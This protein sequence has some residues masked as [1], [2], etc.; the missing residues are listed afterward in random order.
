MSWQ[1]YIDQ[2]L[3]G[4]GN[5]DK[6]AIYDST[7]KS[8]WATSSNFSISPAE[9]DEVVSAFKDKGD[10]NGIKQVQSTGLHV[11]GEKYIVLLAEEDKRIIG[12]KGK[13]GVVIVKTT[14]TIIIT[15]YPETVQPGA[16]TNTVEQLGEYLVSVGY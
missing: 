5:V 4:T 11:A 3:V 9:M 13:E 10:E 16:A 15:H 8:V 2:S 1:A 6:A 12:K 7:G 14:Q